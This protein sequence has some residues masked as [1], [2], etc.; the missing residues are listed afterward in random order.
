MTKE[1]TS[2]LLGI[3]QTAYPR[4]YAGITSEQADATIGLWCVMLS[5]VTL[6]IAKPALYRLISTC[7]FPPTIAEMRESI[8]ALKYDTIPNAGDAWGEVNSA[9]RLFG[10][11]REQEA[12][13]SMCEPVRLVV[14]RMGWR[15]LCLSEN[16]M[17]DRAH[18][19][20]MYEA[21]E[22]QTQEQRLLPT[23]LSER[24][25]L[26]IRSAELPSV[27]GVSS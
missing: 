27:K 7:K 1:E 2:L 24:I 23:A 14:Q 5:D 15:E 26:C 19:L 21:M 4:F 16:D 10:Y 18:F 8:S 13:A 22:R 20:R 12:L 25:S 17:A 11:Y 3:L 9:I 6:E